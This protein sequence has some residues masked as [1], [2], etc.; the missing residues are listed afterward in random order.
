MPAHRKSNLSMYIWRSM[1]D[2]EIEG[3]RLLRLPTHNCIRFVN[4]ELQTPEMRLMRKGGGVVEVIDDM[5]AAE[6]EG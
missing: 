6:S 1:Q 4:E 3:G 5:K 2:I